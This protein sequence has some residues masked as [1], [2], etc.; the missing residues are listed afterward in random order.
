MIAFLK[1]LSNLPLGLL[2]ALGAVGGWVT[3]LV[4]PRYRAVLKANLRSAGYRDAATRRSVVAHTGRAALEIP[5]VWLRPQ[6]EVVGLVT[7]VSGESL[8]ARA[9]S[10]GK[11]VVLLTP[12]LGCFEICAQWCSYRDPLTVLY[13]PPRQKLIEPA[14]MAGRDRPNITLAATD[15]A[16][17]RKLLRALK[18]SEA[19]G[20]L[21]DQV[22][23]FGEGEWAPFFGRSAYTM[24]LVPRLIESTGAALILL[25]AE[26]LPRGAGFHLH[27]IAPPE[28]IA[29]ETPAR[30]TN[31]AVEALI[32][33]C[34]TQYLWS[35]NRFKRPRGAPPP[36]ET[37]A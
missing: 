17:V 30:F 2:H 35:Y 28:P 22:P 21:P 23:S 26:R 20:I 24:T 12:H 8:L 27:F 36:P 37:V 18:R 33:R 13:R 16:G 3:Y 19:V 25:Y 15:L 1:L 11:G 34:P 5:L 4:S 7:K 29:G 9:R 6:S 32:A 31:R 10:E 14:M